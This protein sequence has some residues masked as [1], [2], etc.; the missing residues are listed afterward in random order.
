MDKQGHLEM[1]R[2]LGERNHITVWR[3][4]TYVV[5]G[6]TAYGERLPTFQIRCPL[7]AV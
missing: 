4:V 7:Q 1:I 6:S 5:A 3:Q 2:T